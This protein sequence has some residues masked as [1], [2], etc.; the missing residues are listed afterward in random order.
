[1]RARF[2]AR[3]LMALDLLA[4]VDGVQCTRPTGAFYIFLDVR[5]HLGRTIRGRRIDDD[6]A[7]ADLLLEQGGVALVPGTAF[8]SPG[9]LRMSYATSEQQIREGLSRLAAMLAH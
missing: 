6:V 8:L 1:M 2:D 5:E 3:R 4:T 9:Y 7:L